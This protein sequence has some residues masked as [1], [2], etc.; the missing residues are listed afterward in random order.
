MS[1]FTLDASVA[2]QLRRASEIVELRDPSGRVIGHF[3]PQINPS[4]WESA[5][6]E[7]T[8]DEE[9]QIYKENK[10]Y[11]FDEVTAHLKSLGQK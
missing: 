3:T 8:D 9:A 4:D 10:W 5:G 6:P 1:H 2:E 11:T 7:L